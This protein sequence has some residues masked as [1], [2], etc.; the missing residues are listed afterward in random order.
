MSTGNKKL[1]VTVIGSFIACAVALLCSASSAFGQVSTD[2]SKWTDSSSRKAGARQT[3]K[4]GNVEVAL[5]WV[6][7]A[8]FD[9]GSPA[10]EQGRQSG[11][12]QIHVKLTRGYWM[13]ETEVTQALYEKV[14]GT[15]PSAKTGK[16]FPVENVSWEDATKFCEELTKLL[17]K[18]MIVKLPTEAQWENACR[19][20]TQT[21]YSYGNAADPGKM[22]CNESHKNGTVPVKRYPANAWGLYDMHGNVY[23]WVRDG[24]VESY[25][26][27]YGAGTIVDPEGVPSASGER[28]VRGGGWTEGASRS[29]AAKCRS[30]YRGHSSPSARNNRLGFRFELNCE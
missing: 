15:N 16:F 12:D 8:E 9:M 2:V 29:N 27:E 13:L 10:T 21:A 20:G 11:E 23:E 17:P 6:P 30:A 24:Y 25:A 19:A 1:S 7:A 5:V 4:V 26:G 22:N 3:L 18:G 14:M 28:A